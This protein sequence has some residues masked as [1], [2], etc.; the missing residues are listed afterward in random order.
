MKKLSTV[1]RYSRQL[2]WMHWVIAILVIL[3]LSVSFFLEDFP[4][5]L[6]PTAIM[7]HKSLGLTVLFLMLL[8][9]Y[10]LYKLG[11]PALPATLSP[12]EINLARMV[13]M[14]MYLFL[15][16]MPSVGWLMSVFSD[17]IPVWFGLIPLPLPGVMPNAAWGQF[18]FQIHQ[19]IAWILIALI[20]LHIVGAFKHALID[21]DKV[22][23]SMLP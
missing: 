9:F 19:S 4:K 16:A 10:W 13:Q 2:I 8:R 18:L 12:W 21:K 5:D 11:R 3:L 6:R 14:A 20:G 7:L 1:T 22:M 23:E 15:I 17:H